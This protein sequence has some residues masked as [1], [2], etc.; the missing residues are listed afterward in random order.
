VRPEE[1]R[2]RLLE[3]LQYYR[4]GTGMER[5]KCDCQ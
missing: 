3:V 5:V 2:R 4:Y 1:V